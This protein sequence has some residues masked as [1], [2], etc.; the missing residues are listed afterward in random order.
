[1]SDVFPRRLQAGVSRVRLAATRRS[2]S[3]WGASL[4]GLCREAD[5]LRKL[6]AASS[7]WQ[8]AAG[9]S[10]VGRAAVV[11]AGRRLPRSTV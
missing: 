8:E 3:A 6:A 4:G 11:G 2:A 9:P 10:R 1:V 7:A 5:R